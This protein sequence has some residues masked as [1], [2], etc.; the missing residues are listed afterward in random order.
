DLVG[1]VENLIRSFKPAR[2]FTSYRV[3]KE[4]EF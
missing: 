4:Y 1:Y 3:D 2:Y